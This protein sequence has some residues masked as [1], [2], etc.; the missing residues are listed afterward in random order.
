MCAV[1]MNAADLCRR[2]NHELGPLLL[3]KFA[4]RGVVLEIQLCVR[5]KRQILEAQRSQPAHDR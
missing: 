5:A 2:H 4:R 3:E 1:R